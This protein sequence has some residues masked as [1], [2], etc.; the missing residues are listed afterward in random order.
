MM[1]GVL[2]H[3]IRVRG[4]GL[5]AIARSVHCSPSYA[6]MKYGMGSERHL[7][8]ARRSASAA[9]RRAPVSASTLRGVMEH[10]EPKF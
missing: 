2:S 6:E 5:A 9:D 3:V 8:G 10:C 4:A 7:K 1:H